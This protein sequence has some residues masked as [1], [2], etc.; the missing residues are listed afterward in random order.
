MHCTVA[1]D[2]LKG[3]LGAR[4]MKAAIHAEGW[5]YR[6]S[7]GPEYEGQEFGHGFVRISASLSKATDRSVKRMEMSWLPRRPW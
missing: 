1:F 4:R 6:V 2:C 7:V 5:T 3:I